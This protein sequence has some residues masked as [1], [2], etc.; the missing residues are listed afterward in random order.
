MSEE[1]KPRQSW[2]KREDETWPEHRARIMADAS[3][4]MTSNTST[5]CPAAEYMGLK[6]RGGE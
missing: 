2:L 3:P 4:G 6:S 1:K 5:P